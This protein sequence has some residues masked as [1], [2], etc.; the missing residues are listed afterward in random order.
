MRLLTKKL[1]SAFK[2]QGDTSGKKS[3]YTKII[4]KYFNPDGRGSWYATEYDPE[5]KMFYGFVSIFNDYNDEIGSFS[6]K[7]LENFKSP[8]GLK[9]ERDKFFEIGKYTLKEIMDGKRP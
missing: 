2:K 9:I 3:K 7:G 8:C 6:L 4:A 5:T 1:L